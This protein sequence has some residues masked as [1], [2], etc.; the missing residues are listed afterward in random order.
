MVLIAGIL[1]FERVRLGG[2]LEIYQADFPAVAGLQMGD[3]VQ[4]RGI[5]MGTVTSFA[6]V[7]HQVRVAF[8]LEKGADLRED[9]RVKLATK[10]IVGEVLLDIDPGRGKP[11][12]PGHLFAG[13]AA[14]SIESVTAAA[15]RTMDSVQELSAELSALVT[16]LRGEGRLVATL[17][18]TRAAVAGLSGMVAEN[19]GDLR[20]LVQDAAASA[21]AL[22]EVLADTSLAAALRGAGGTFAR[23]DTLLADVGTTAARLDSLLARVAAGEGTAGR[24]LNNEDL[25]VHADSAMIS[26]HRL[27]DQLRRDPKRFF[28]MSVLDF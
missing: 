5:R 3:R 26:L 6:V 11:V 7:E 17:D 25:Y 1:W 12:P 2:S 16:E 21:A 19:R 22:R 10:G 27:L 8:Q 28:K 15:G 24:L 4:V 18:D 14:M 13:E 20:A 9:A 23:A